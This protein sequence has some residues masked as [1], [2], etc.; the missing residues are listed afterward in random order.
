MALRKGVAYPESLF[1]HFKRHIGE[2]KTFPFVCHDKNRK[3][4]TNTF[5]IDTNAFLNDPQILDGIAER[6]K[7]IVP[8]SIYE[9]LN[10]H[11]GKEET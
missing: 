7:V 11:L 2:E 3:P 5:I 8:M 6:H 10:Y 9:E 1:K 4:K